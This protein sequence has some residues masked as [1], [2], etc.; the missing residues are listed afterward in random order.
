MIESPVLQRLLQET[1]QET[2]RETRQETRRES[3][4]RALVA[5]F[6]V[7]APDIEAMLKSIGDD[8]RLNQLVDLAVT[9]PDLDSFRKQLSP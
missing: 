6:R 2:R 4:L 8:E 7:T 9:C 3:I 1:K 5:R